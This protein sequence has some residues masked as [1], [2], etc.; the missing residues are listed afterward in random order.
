V[1]SAL[2]ADVKSTETAPPTGA[3]RGVHAGANCGTA[4]AGAGA[5]WL[6]KNARGS[7][8]PPLISL[9]AVSGR[10]ISLR[11]ITFAT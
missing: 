8:D 10:G 9:E 7:C 3:I 5:A 11:R 2:P 6:R 4:A 1:G